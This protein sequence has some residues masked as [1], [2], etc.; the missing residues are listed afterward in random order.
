MVRMGTHT[1]P[2]KLYTHAFGCR[3]SAADVAEMSGALAERG[4]ALTSDIS[5]ADAVLV[6]TCT[7]RE[8]A[9]HRALSYIGRLREWKRARPSGTLIV[10][11]C[12]AERLGA[13][14]KRRF[15]HVDLVTGSKSVGSF[16]AL[17]DYFSRGAACL[18]SP[19]LPGASGDLSPGPAAP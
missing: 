2:S 17:I 8:H 9:E 15:P 10:A 3:M 7:V 12:A 16:Q 13:D 1:A 19:R 14:L 4:F 6:G 5:E 18:P 11:G